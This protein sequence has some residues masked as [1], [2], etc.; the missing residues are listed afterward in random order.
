MYL[1]ADRWGVKIGG[2]F[3]ISQF[4]FF[5][6]FFFFAGEEVYIL[7]KNERNDHLETEEALLKGLSFP[8]LIYYLV[9]QL[10]L[11]LQGT[12]RL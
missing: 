11:I 10:H 5:F 7:F 4:K 6:F 1:C 9:P 12:W 8:G 3:I 2:V